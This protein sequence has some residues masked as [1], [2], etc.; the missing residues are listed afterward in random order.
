ML[1]RQV[2]F[3]VICTTYNSASFVERTLVSIIDQT[4]KDYEIIISDDGSSDNTWEVCGK[5]LQN[6]TENPYRIIRNVHRGPGAARN[7]GLRVAQGQWIALLDSDDCWE[8]Y[9]LERVIE[10]IQLNREINFIC[11]NEQFNLINGGEKILDYAA[12]YNV[13]KPLVPQLFRQNL[14]STSAV[15]FA[16]KL[17]NYSGYFNERLMSAQDYEMWLKMSPK[18]KVYFMQDCLGYYFERADNISSTNWFKRWFN[19]LKIYFMHHN[20]VKFSVFIGVLIYHFC[21]LGKPIIRR[22]LHD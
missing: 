7:A 14:F 19:V 8:K 4:Y 12:M 16:K 11:H 3:S 20:K 18:I 9:K 13:E 22:I 5:F 15:V 1:N 2:F 17:L 21:Y 10:V 6:Y